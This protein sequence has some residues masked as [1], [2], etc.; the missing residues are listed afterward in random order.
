MAKLGPVRG[1]RGK[2]PRQI[3]QLAVHEHV[4]WSEWWRAWKIAD[5]EI[6]A[7]FEAADVKPFPGAFPKRP[8]RR[9]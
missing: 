7:D 2:Q 4:D 5:K 6:E 1:K 9:R 8:K 3:G